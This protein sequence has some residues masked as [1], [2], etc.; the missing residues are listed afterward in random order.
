MKITKIPYFK[1]Q[2]LDDY[3]LENR[4]KL[5]DLQHVVVENILRLAQQSAGHVSYCDESEGFENPAFDRDLLRSVTELT[6]NG[7]SALTSL[8]KAELR[9]LNNYL[10][11]CLRVPAGNGRP[12][13]RDNADV[14]L[15]KNADMAA[16]DAA[17]K[18]LL[19][20][21][22]PEFRRENF[23]LARDQL[24]R[25]REYPGWLLEVV[26]CLVTV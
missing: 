3:R 9:S 17:Q 13:L 24:V 23:D 7:E 26:Y 19:N 12:V 16:H 21:G 14:R 15:H 6:L 20:L 10:E 5:T 2:T 11:G 4:I 1:L 18:A 8:K 25:R 22:L